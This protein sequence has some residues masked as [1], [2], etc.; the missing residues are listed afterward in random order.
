MIDATAIIDPAAHIGYPAPDRLHGAIKCG[1]GIERQESLVTVGA[2]TIIRSGA[3]VYEGVTIGEDGD[4]G[5]NAV[6]REGAHLFARVRI[7]P[8]AYIKTAVV[9][10]SGSKVAGVVADRTQ[11]GRVCTVLG[12]TSHEFGDGVA[13]LVEDAP[14]IMDG[15]IVGRGAIIVGDVRVGECAYVGAGSVVLEDVPDRALV[16]GNPARLVRIRSS[17]ELGRIRDALEELA[18]SD[19]E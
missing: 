12:N 14:R 1:R 17:E 8:F 13:G 18:R 7:D 16:V 2:R 11:I 6:I 15:A 5:H 3:V 9:I 4:I 19:R 10:G